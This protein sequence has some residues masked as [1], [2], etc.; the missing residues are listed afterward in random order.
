MKRLAVLASGKGSNLRAILETPNLGARV[1]VL[2]TDREEA[3]AREVARRFGV[4]DIFL[5]PA[6]YPDRA[7]HEAAM[8]AAMEDF[9]PD[10]VVLAGYMRLV[11]PGFLNR[12]PG[13]I[14]NIHPSLL[15]AFPGLGAV[16]KA[17]EYGVRV[18]GCTVHFVD[19]GL[20][21]GPIILQRVV[22][23]E[24]G[25]TPESLRARIQAEEHRAYPE[26]IQLFSTGRLRI[27]GRRVEILGGGD[28]L[29]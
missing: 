6:D 4:P 21:T 26:A 20:D 16:E 11:G 13:R 18:T 2:L 22:P 15:P 7:A 17:L 19:E 24:S 1:A 29:D 27:R 14:M 10:L 3:G 25:D 5:P 28:S 8:L 12:Y 23:V 9:R